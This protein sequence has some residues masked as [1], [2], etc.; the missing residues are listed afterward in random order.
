LA[1]ATVTG[2]AAAVGY[3]GDMGC[4]AAMNIRAA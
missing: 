1:K 3:G 4:F 2:E